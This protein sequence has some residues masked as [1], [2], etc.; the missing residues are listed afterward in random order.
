MNFFL[1]VGACLGHAALLVFLLSRWYA[2]PLPRL[3]LSG[4]R[5]FVALATVIG[6]VWLWILFGFDV[7]QAWHSGPVLAIYLST[8]WIIGLGIVPSLTI[9]RLLRKRPQALV[10][11]HTRTLDVAKHLGYNPIGR[12]KYRH[13][14]LLPWNEA[15]QVPF[16]DPASPLP[17]PP[18]TLTP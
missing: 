17:R 7:M 3:M 5:A 13:L 10:S 4:F 14:A 16:P 6:P 8:C 18:P 11:N 12:G 15:F 9:I 2:L 1:F